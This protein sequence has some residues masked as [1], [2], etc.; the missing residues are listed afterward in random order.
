MCI[1]TPFEKPG[2]RECREVAAIAPAIARGGGAAAAAELPGVILAHDLAVPLFE[3]AAIRGRRA[4]APRF[5]VVIAPLA[6]FL[7]SLLVAPVHAL[8]LAAL[9]AASPG[10]FFG[11]HRVC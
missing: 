1:T 3:V 10:G 5:R 8:A 9:V 4:V 6:F 7:A 11:H 2:E